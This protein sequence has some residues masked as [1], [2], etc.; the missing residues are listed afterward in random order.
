MNQNEIFKLLLLILLLTNE[1]DPCSPTTNC[2][3]FASLNEIII[4]VLLLSTSNTPT[5][6][7]DD[8]PIIDTTF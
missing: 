5:P 2:G 4:I 3:P 7:L 6:R 8:F 1:K